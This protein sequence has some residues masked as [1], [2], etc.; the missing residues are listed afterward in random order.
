MQ[1]IIKR[2]FTLIELLVVIAIIGILAGIVLASLS[3]ARSG[4]NDSK[5]KEQLSGMRNAMEAYYAGALNY[6]PSAVGDGCPAAA[7]NP[8]VDPWKDT[9]SGMMSLADQDN[10]P[11]G[12][13]L[14]CF[15]SGTAW[16]AQATLSDATFWCVDSSGAAKGAAATMLGGVA[17]DTAC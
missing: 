16:A 10:Y 7:A 11:T 4:A 13:T 17:P 6:G 8:S 15:T 14:V 9:A 2:G 5:I 1:K 12:S 3:N